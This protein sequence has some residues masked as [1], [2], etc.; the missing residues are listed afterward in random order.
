MK[1]QKKSS[2]G[3]EVMNGDN[4]TKNPKKPKNTSDIEEKS[5]YSHPN[6]SES[7]TNLNIFAANADGLQGKQV[8]LKHEIDEAKA[9]IFLYSR[10]KV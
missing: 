10:D 5:K 6:N 4:H 1:T 7:S 9:S 2:D 3:D 8:S